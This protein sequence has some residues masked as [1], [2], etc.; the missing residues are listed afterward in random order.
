MKKV[1]AITILSLYF[2]L[3]A[4]QVISI[5]LCHGHLQS[6]VLS[7]PGEDCCSGMHGGD[8]PCCEDI[9]IEID[10]DTDHIYTEELIVRSSLETSAQFAHLTEL[11]EED[12][13]SVTILSIPFE[14]PPP[15]QEIYK[16]TSAFLFYG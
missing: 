10:F 16:L 6:V 2:A 11:S 14:S 15:T 1:V 7:L 13:I 8:S 9:I 3:T 12:N 4:I 5:H